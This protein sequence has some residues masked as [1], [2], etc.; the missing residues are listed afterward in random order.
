VLSRFEVEIPYANVQAVTVKQG[1][2]QRMFGCGD[3]RVA[4]HGVSGPTLV[5]SKDLNSITIRSIPDWR[6]VGEILRE[7]M[8]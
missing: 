2:V 7:R 5:T 1:I 4:A 8:G 3:V 6:E